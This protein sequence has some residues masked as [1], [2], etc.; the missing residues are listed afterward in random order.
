MA[1]ANSKC[2]PKC[3]EVCVVATIVLMAVAIIVMITKKVI[4]KDTSMDGKTT[5]TKKI[6][7]IAEAE[8]AEDDTSNLSKWNIKGDFSQNSP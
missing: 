8:I 7:I 6:W 5:K 4:V 3:V 2:V 1:K